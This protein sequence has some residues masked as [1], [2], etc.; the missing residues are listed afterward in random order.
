MIYNSCGEKSI[1]EYLIGV[2]QKITFDV[3]FWPLV[4]SVFYFRSGRVKK[5]GHYLQR[6]V[7]YE[8]KERIN[9]NSWSADWQYLKVHI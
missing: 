7:I 5:A 4:V 6:R 3:M 9:K 2:E 1:F 8:R